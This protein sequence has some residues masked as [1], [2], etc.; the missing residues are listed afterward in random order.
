MSFC[1]GLCMFRTYLP[2]KN[3]I[4]FNSVYLLKTYNEI[5][6]STLKINFINTPPAK[7][8]YFVMVYFINK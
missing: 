1:K 8:A 2:G 6:Y 3:K 5:K 4:I 7:S